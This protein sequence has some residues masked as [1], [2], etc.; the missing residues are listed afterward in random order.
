[1]ASIY[2]NIGTTGILAEDYLRGETAYRQAGRLLLLDVDPEHAN[3]A[4]IH[5]GIGTA[6]MGQ[7]RLLE[8]D[9]EL[10]RA[11]KIA[12]RRHGAGSNRLVSIYTNIGR[13][14][15]AQGRLDESRESFDHSVRLAFELDSVYDELVAGAWLGIVMLEQGEV[16]T[17]RT[18]LERC[19]SLMEALG[20]Q[21]AARYGMVE[22]ALGLALA[23]QGDIEGGQTLAQ[24]GLAGM[25]D[26]G[27]A[28]GNFY[29]EAISLYSQFPVDQK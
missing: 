28:T 17:A 14:R 15:R 23:R 16:A 7:G 19:R 12:T 27:Q 1:L 5:Q 2:N 24:A 11:L 8:A 18:V 29:A 20:H 22:V 6:L 9:D 13:L 26:R 3:M 10:T 21:S 4:F 25:L